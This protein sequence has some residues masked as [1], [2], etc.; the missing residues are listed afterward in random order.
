MLTVD[1][2]S[3]AWG[4][5]MFLRIK[6]QL[7]NL[8]V[9]CILGFIFVFMFFPRIT[10]ALAG[11]SE[12]SFEYYYSPRLL[13][14]FN[15]PSD[16]CSPEYD[17]NQSCI[18]LYQVKEDKYSS[19]IQYKNLDQMKEINF[20]QSVDPAQIIGKS[21]YD[22]KWFIFDLENDKVIVTDANYDT[23]EQQW[24]KLGFPE[25]RLVTTNNFNKY[26]HKQTK[27]SESKNNELEDFFT[28]LFITGFAVLAILLGGIFGMFYLNNY[29]LNKK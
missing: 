10:F 29:F 2:S 6:E 28:G 21:Y 4:H 22:N 27:E 17:K 23:V 12:Q 14:N 8:H 5:R 16:S 1:L 18:E 15:T 11:F 7:N 26:F 20:P 9:Q 25:P 24:E 19:N 13:I 3:S